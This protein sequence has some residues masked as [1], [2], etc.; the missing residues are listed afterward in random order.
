M[1]RRPLIA[2]E[3]PPQERRSAVPRHIL[4]LAG[5]GFRGL[6][7]ARVLERMEAGPPRR[8]L[9]AR[10]DLLAG[11]SIGG[12]L[13]IGIAA[14]VSASD[15]VALMREHG[16]AIFR[17][18]LT[19]LGGLVSSR[20]DSDALRS[21]ITRILGK[22]IANRDFCEIPT[23]L[24]VVAVNERTCRPR[25]FRTNRLV[26]GLGD[27]IR[28][29]DVALATSAAPTFFQPHI[30]GDNSYVDG[31]LIANAPDIVALTEAMRSL[32]ATLED[33]HVC[34]IG[35][36]ASSRTGK[37][38]GSAPGKIGWGIRHGVI[39]LIMDSQ[40]ALI[41]DQLDTLGPASVLRIDRRPARTISLD[42]IAPATA[43]ELVGLAD[44]AVEDVLAAQTDAWHRFLT[45]TG[46]R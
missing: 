34:C 33:I 31:G 20:Y 17:R 19:S 23:P 42:D 6:F 12:I 7:T 40:S 44:S 9:A 5:G 46:G 45:H 26:P 4:S 37:A 35:T 22:E 15:L 43:I 24:L 36:A 8:P 27:K 10:F 32:G 30:V 21:A 25:I 39:E 38:A 11:T 41:A 18:K 13:A 1:T 14:G 29:I 3:L 2:G 28:T 16:P